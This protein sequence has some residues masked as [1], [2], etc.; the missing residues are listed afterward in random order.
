MPALGTR[1]GPNPPLP[2]EKR[3]EIIE[4]YR[5][6]KT[7]KEVAI[8]CNVSF[9]T[10]SRIVREIAG[11]GPGGRPQKEPEPEPRREI[12]IDSLMAHYFTMPPGEKRQQFL[13][14]IVQRNNKS[15]PTEG[16]GNDSRQA[17]GLG[18]GRSGATA[19]T[20]RRRVPGAQPQ[21]GRTD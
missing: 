5:R 20:E 14:R 21:G 18:L 13:S 2:P 12:S 4:T 19:V 6:L 8:A 3:R 9:S 1:K 11:S 7:R 17:R 16:N 15:T 10:V